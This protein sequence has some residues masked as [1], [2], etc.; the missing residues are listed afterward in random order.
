MGLLN[1]SFMR[2]N[3]FELAFQGHFPAQERAGELQEER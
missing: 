2:K 3:Q 1:V